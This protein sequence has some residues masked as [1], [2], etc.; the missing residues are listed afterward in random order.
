[1]RS[2]RWT[3]HGARQRLA[4]PTLRRCEL[5]LPRLLLPQMLRTAPLDGCGAIAASPFSIPPLA[6]AGA[7][8]LENFSRYWS[9]LTSGHTV[10]LP[11]HTVNTVS[12][13]RPQD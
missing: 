6:G 11:V 2:A 8:T 7:A 4:I 5:T 12:S 13:D 1:M 10:F 3:F 9:T